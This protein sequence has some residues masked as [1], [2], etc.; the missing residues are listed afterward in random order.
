MSFDAIL[1]QEKAVRLIRAGLKRERV[2]HAYLFSGPPGAGKREAALELAKALNCPSAPRD[3]SCDRCETCRRI[4]HGNHPDVV[5]L[6]PEG[7]SIKID[8]VRRLQREFAYAAAEAEYRVVIIEEA[9]TMTVEAANSML[10]FLE[11]P[12][13]PMVAVLIADREDAVLP[14]IRSR[15]QQIR[16]V[17]PLPEHLEQRLIG[18]GMDPALARI[19]AH[20]ADGGEAARRLAGGEEFARLCEQVIK[21]S[22]EVLAGR[23]DA[24]ISL[25][26]EWMRGNPD[27][28]TL[29]TVLELML[30]WL[31][32]LLNRMLGRTERE[33]FTRWDAELRRQSAGWTPSRLVQAMDCVIQA[34]RQLSGPVQPQAVF[35]QMV[36]AIQE[37]S[38]HVRSDRS[39][40]STSG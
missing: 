27:K 20:L 21:W 29:E 7:T 36:L 32:D 39:P 19:A 34:R 14:T 31:R 9:E 16:F 3:D 28:K 18:E 13:T 22:G 33:V 8:Q 37:G 17:Q 35:E 38:F 4:E 2:A 5:R 25:Q 30:L 12:V 1:G 15:C 11:E 23:G 24:L 10:K 40:L 6:A 26:T